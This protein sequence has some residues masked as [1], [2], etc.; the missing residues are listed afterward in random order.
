MRWICEGV[1]ASE[2]VMALATCRLVAEELQGAWLSVRK[3]AN[4]LC[5]VKTA[6]KLYSHVQM[7]QKQMLHM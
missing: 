3:E 5:L 2:S 1:K 6:V 7:Q 4:V